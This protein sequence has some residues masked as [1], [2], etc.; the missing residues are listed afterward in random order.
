[1]KTAVVYFSLDGSTRVAAQALAERLQ[2]DVYELKEIKQRGKTK[3]AF[4][5]EA[6]GALFGLKSRVQDTFAQKMGGYERVCIGTPIWA[7]SPVPAVNTFLHA[8][9]P[10]GKQILL[11]TVQADPDTQTPPAK[12]IEQLC[13]ALRKKGGNVL[14]VLRLHGAAPGATAARADMEA[15]LGKKLEDII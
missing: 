13:A 7:G 14:P 8:L 15:Q 1:M 5:G 3:G 10:S 2:A 11:F 9:N 6:V 4:M 12:K